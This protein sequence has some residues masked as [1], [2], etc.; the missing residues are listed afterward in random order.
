MSR[1]SHMIRMDRRE[2]GGVDGGRWAV[3]CR[4]GQS[5]LGWTTRESAHLKGTPVSFWPGSWSVAA[6][7]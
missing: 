5:L 7:V 1:E 4:R 6:L 2:R 3:E